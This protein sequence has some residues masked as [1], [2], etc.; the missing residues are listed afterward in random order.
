MF[1][2]N[3][4]PSESRDLDK[5]EGKAFA[6]YVKMKP[7][8][9]YTVEWAHVIEEVLSLNNNALRGRAGP[10]IH[11]GEKSLCHALREGIAERSEEQSGRGRGWGRQEI[12]AEK[13]GRCPNYTAA[14][15]RLYTNAHVHAFSLS[16]TLIC[17]AIH[18]SRSP[19]KP[20]THSDVLL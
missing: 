17:S 7:L 10:G 8:I 11:L 4:A 2:V 5:E 19:Q 20:E 13:V 15:Q 3:K 1:H 16:Q 9:K 18:F 14:C 12:P 6:Q